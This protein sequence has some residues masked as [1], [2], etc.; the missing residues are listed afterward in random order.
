MDADKII[1]IDEGRIIAE[2]NHHELLESCEEYKQVV[3]SQITKEEAMNSG[4]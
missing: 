1:F 2:G 4:K 3:M